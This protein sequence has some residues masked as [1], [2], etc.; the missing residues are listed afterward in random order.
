MKI[1]RLW[2]WHLW[3]LIL[4]ARASRYNLTS[5]GLW[6]KL[7]E[8]NVNVISH[9]TISVND[10]IPY[11]ISEFEWNASNFFM[12]SREIA[13]IMGIWHERNFTIQNWS[14]P[15]FR[16]MLKIAFEHEFSVD[17][18]SLTHYWFRCN[19]YFF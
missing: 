4:K 15:L 17:V 7:R 19:L 18:N 8:L 2:N 6:S 13:K 14:E 11:I 10:K 1:H 5:D 16:E 12:I 9:F 3:I